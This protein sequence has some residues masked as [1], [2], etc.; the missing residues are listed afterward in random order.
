[1]PWPSP[2]LTSLCGLLDGRNGAS[3]PFADSGLITLARR[4]RVEPLLYA[5]LTAAAGGWR[6]ANE[7]MDALAQDYRKNTERVLRSLA[8]FQQLT[9]ALESHGIEAR[10]LKGLPLA[11]QA[12]ER[13]ADRHCGDLDLLINSHR[14]RARADAVMRT[15]GL[16]PSYDTPEA[17]ASL[18]LYRALTYADCYVS[19]EGTRVEIHYLQDGVGHYVFPDF[20]DFESPAW[21]RHRLASAVT[22]RLHGPPLLL[23]LLSHGARSGWRRLKWLV[24]LRRLT[25]DFDATAWIELQH[26]AQGENLGLQT[27]VGLRLLN[28]V[29]QI[30]SLSALDSIAGIHGSRFALRRCR[31]QLN[32]ASASLE[33]LPPSVLDTVYDLLVQRGW[34]ARLV[35][36]GPL[37]V[38]FEDI[39]R[40]RLP[41]PLILVLAPIARP[42]SFVYR[43]A[44]RPLARR[45]LT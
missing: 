28:D 26:A 29:F 6:P 34:R 5:R 16:R 27:Q 21:E 14:L 12:Y 37:W 45:L 31:V 36:T 2:E 22:H 24:D 15:L 7:T 32:E 25:H 44:V 39:A 18:R 13:V 33:P 10:P 35:V 23:Y 30:E 19:T 17:G 11:A 38:R 8:S 3:W 4:H 40:W 1:M 43:R 9:E 42:F 20:M 41:L